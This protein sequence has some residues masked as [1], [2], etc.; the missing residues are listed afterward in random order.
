MHP[1]LDLVFYV[2][3]SI[4]FF[5]GAIGVTSRIDWTLSGFLFLSLTLWIR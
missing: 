1:N 3:A 5:C 4:C 2:L